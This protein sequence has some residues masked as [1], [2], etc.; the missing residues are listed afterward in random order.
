MLALAALLLPVGPGGLGAR[1]DELL[2]MP[3]ACTMVG[4]QPVLSPGPEQSHRIIGQ[5][6]RRKHTAC[7]PANPGMCRHWI[8][9]R[10][11][12]DCD[13]SRVS[14]VS[15]VAASNEGSRRA[16]LLDGRLVLRMGPWWSLASDDPCARKP[17]P[18]ARFEYRRMRS[19]CAD[20]LALAPPPVVEMPFGYA[21][22]FGIDGIFVT[23]APGVRAAP[24]PLPPLAAAPL[25]PARATAPEPPRQMPPSAPSPSWAAEPV[26][27]PGA[28]EAPAKLPSPPAPAPVAA[29]QPPAPPAKVAAAPPAPPAPLRAEAPKAAPAETRPAVN[30]GPRI[31]APSPPPTA[32]A[33]SP[34]V[35]VEAKPAA[36]AVNL[37]PRVIA[38]TPPPPDPAPATSAAARPSAANTTVVEAKP[39][40]SG[41][42]PGPKVVAA[43]SPQPKAVERPSAAPGS[44]AEP[45]G[46]TVSVSLFSALRTTTT[47][48]LVAFAGL[49]LG[50]LTAFALARRRERAHDA[51]R[52]PRDLAAVS[53]GDKRARASGRLADARGHLP[54]NAAASA[55]GREPGRNAT[56]GAATAWG[57][58]MPNT[59]AEALE[60][61]GIGLAPSANLAAIKKIVDGLRQSWHPD[62]AKD[63]ADRALRELRSKQIN[64]AWDLLRSQ[65][66][67]V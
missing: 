36:P 20:R 32:T 14:W 22:M 62:L 50:L 4:G 24:Q 7:S 45:Q 64:A 10:F 23:A 60:V 66:A 53:L 54:P 34:P 26:R 13:G 40:A 12:L 63:E 19:H 58:R 65:V 2:V 16:W 11:D 38:P 5:R 57:D 17:D 39:A 27:E 28:K 35:P 42:A 30:L 31:V 44:P 25:P 49:A 33:P 55:M 21:P 1:A 56:A 8:V 15:V 46:D 3:Y 52:R 51:R 48:A 59:R 47:G 6:D 61:L 41:P 29:Q 18:D 37:G 43:P 9:H 67:E